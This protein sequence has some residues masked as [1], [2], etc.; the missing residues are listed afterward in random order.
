MRVLLTW[1]PNYTR[2]MIRWIVSNLIVLALLIASCMKTDW[3]GAGLLLVIRCTYIWYIRQEQ[4]TIPAEIH[5]D[6]LYLWEDRY[7]RTDIQ[8]ISIEINES[9]PAFLWLYIQRVQNKRNTVYWFSPLQDNK[10][11][12]QWVKE[13]EKHV[14][15]HDDITLDSYHKVRRW[16]RI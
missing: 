2:P 4:E 6:A 15:L 14:P 12:S 8:H 7:K 13:L 3:F 1:N 9:Q 5:E 16:L 10:D 11:I